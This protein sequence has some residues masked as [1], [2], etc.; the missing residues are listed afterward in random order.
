MSA[1]F[2][3]PAGPSDVEALVHLRREMFAA[4]DVAEHDTTWRDNAAAWFESH[5]DDEKHGIFVVEHESQVVACA[6]GTL[7]DSAPSPGVPRGG[8]VVVSN[9]CT[10]PSYRG[11]GMGRL[12]F[13]A[14]M[15]WARATG[16]VRAELMATPAGRSM[17]A[18]AG[19]S[20]VKFSAMR[21]A[22]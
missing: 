19:F 7:Q 6:M 18:R 10:L 14:V 3:H 20:D 17:Y 15:E 21:A 13:N 5:I 9:V 8:F 12:A 22:L 2:V 16:A 4:M 11:R 1:T